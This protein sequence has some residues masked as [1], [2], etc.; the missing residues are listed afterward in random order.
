[1]LFLTILMNFSTVFAASDKVYITKIRAYPVFTMPGSNSTY[2]VQDQYIQRSFSN[3]SYSGLSITATQQN[4]MYNWCISNGYKQVGWRAEMYYTVNTSNPSSCTMRS[5]V[6]DGSPEEVRYNVTPHSDVKVYSV[7][8]L[9]KISSW[10]GTITRPDGTS[11][12]FVGAV[13]I[14]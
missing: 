10:S 7:I 9:S 12:S 13:Y 3:S 4:E 6:D 5:A 1:M 14:L 2:F 8:S 11:F